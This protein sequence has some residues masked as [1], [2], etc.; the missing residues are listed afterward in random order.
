M[1]CVRAEFPLLAKPGV[2]VFSELGTPLTNEFC[3]CTNV[4]HVISFRSTAVACLTSRLLR[5]DLGSQHSYGLAHTPARFRQDWLDAKTP[6][7]G[8]YL[9]GH[10]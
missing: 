7:P 6:V 3:E 1:V 5:T 10:D 9:T 2:L 4:G 8:L